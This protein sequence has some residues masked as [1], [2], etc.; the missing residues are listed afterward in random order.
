MCDAYMYLSMHGSQRK[1][2]G[3][4]SY[5]PLWVPGIEFRMPGLSGKYFYSLS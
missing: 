2:W 1:I 4:S 5:V 3:A